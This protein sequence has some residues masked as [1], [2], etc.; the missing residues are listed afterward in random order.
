MTRVDGLVMV[1]AALCVVSCVAQNDSTGPNDERR[2]FYIADNGITIVCPEA[3]LG[4]KGLVNGIEY[5]KRGEEELRNLARSG[6][7]DATQ[8]SLMS[9]TCTSGI[10]NMSG[11]VHFGSNG[12]DYFDFPFGGFNEDISTWDTGYVV[13]MSRMFYGA[14]SFN[15]P[16]GAWDTSNVT[17]M[18]SMF[19]GAYA[20]NQSIGSWNTSR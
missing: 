2:L 12:L 11:L 4:S 17:T 10:T 6:I 18:K 20:F 1:L 14:S 16:I 9:V 19:G 13:D 15:Q 8:W 3:P 5:T 7:V